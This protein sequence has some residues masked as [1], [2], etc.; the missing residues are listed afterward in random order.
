MGITAKEVN[1]LRKKTGAGMMDCKKALT[2]SNGNMESAID[3]LRKKGQK[4]AA[5][6]GDRD[7]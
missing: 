2:E 7:A 5:K 6:R 4:I 1:E 3:F